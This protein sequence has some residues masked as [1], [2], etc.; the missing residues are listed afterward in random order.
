VFVKVVQLAS[1]FVKS[2]DS[3]FEFGFAFQL[4]V[5]GGVSTMEIHISLFPGDVQVC[6][7]VTKDF[8]EPSVAREL[9]GADVAVVM[10]VG[11]LNLDPVMAEVSTNQM[12]PCNIVLAVNDARPI[13]S[14]VLCRWDSFHIPSQEEGR[15]G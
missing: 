8:V 9:L 5:G 12:S 3:W 11:L 1:C 2:H 7:E 4:L 10:D 14:C 13:R 6:P 15:F